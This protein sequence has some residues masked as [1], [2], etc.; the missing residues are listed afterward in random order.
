MK[1]LCAPL[2]IAVALLWSPVAG[3]AVAQVGFVPDGRAT[4][5]PAAFGRLVERALERL[6]EMPA[7][8]DA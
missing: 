5:A 2:A 7:P 3:T 1:K 6:G 4:L 8:G